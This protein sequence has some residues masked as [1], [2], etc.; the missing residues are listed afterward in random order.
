[1]SRSGAAAAGESITP[2]EERVRVRA[3]VFRDE[4]SGRRRGKGGLEW[5][6]QIWAEASLSGGYRK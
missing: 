4:L 6:K 2:R 1:M 3:A 5:K